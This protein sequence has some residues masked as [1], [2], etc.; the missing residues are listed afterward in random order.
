MSTN[1][2]IRISHLQIEQFPRTNFL[3][4]VVKSCNEKTRPERPFHNFVH[5]NGF[6]FFF[7]RHEGLQAIRIEYGGM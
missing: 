6:I 2:R 4:H 5:L 3:E 7:F 1:V